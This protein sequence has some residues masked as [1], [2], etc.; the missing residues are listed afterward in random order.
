MRLK[1]N[2]SE[3]LQI[4]SV[5]NRLDWELDAF[6][7]WALMIISLCHKFAAAGREWDYTWGWTLALQLAV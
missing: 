1:I 2:E 5:S 4:K 6:I 3:D 7:R